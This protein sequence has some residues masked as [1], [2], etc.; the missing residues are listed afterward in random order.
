[1]TVLAALLVAVGTADLVRAGDR[2]T[3]ARIRLVAP[4]VGVLVLA[5]LALATGLTRPLDLALFILAAGVLVA[6]TALSGRALDSGRG[7]TSALAAL[8]A[9]VVALAALSGA[10]SE[11]DGVLGDWLAWLA[12][13]PLEGVAPQRF[14]L[15]AGVFLVQLS[16]ANAVVRIVLARVGAIRPVGQPQPSDRLRGGRLLGPMERVFIV[17]LGLAGEVTAAGIV[18]AAKGLIRWPELQERPAEP[19]LGVDAVTEYFLVGSFM[20]WMLALGGLWLAAT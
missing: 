12:L 4:A 20:S 9:G 19:A 11:A 7:G 13:P 16:T 10:T 15:L 3:V 17:A 5:A 8:A 14:L 6:W 18:I 2:A 1:V